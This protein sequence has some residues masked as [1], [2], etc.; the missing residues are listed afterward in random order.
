MVV[1]CGRVLG[2]VWWNLV[3]R[4]CYEGLL[5]GLVLGLWDFPRLDFGFLS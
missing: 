3:V 4:G 5:V 2:V 1:L